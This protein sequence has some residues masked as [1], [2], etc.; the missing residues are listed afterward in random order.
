[1]SAY[2]LRLK[3]AEASLESWPEL[4]GDESWRMDEGEA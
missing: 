2:G 4:L 3:S 1:M